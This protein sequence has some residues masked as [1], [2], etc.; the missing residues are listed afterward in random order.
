MKK[1]VA[2]LLTFTVVFSTTT[3]AFANEKKEECNNASLV[4]DVSAIIGGAE[5]NGAPAG[6]T[7]GGEVTAEGSYELE[8]VTVSNAVSAI[9]IAIGISG[10]AAYITLGVSAAIGIGASHIYWVKKIAYGEDSQYYYV[11][12]KVRLY[13]DV[14]HTKPLADWHTVYT[15]KSKNSGASTEGE[16]L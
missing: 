10:I 2:L 14:K 9:G 5:I 13:S 8:G 3:V 6:V 12:T 7:F 4:E 1:M 16:I 11:R 15:K